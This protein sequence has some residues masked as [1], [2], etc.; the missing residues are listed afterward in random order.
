MLED[1][2]SA[3]GDGYKTP[4]S[5]AQTITSQ[6]NDQ[7]GLAIL[8]LQHGLDQTVSRLNMIE[9]DLNRSM[10][11]IRRLESQTYAKQ[12]L[13]GVGYTTE[14]ERNSSSR[15]PRGPIET[16]IGCLRRMDSMHW[17]Y[18]SYPILVYVLVRTFER[19][20]RGRRI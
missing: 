5:L 8:R 14:R 6:M 1:T 10:E 19:H 4:S 2:Q 9:S 20:R 11:A 15:R 16:A 3:G 13:E 12:I 17:F 18:L 7:V